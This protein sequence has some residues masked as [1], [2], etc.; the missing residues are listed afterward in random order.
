MFH[1]T[2]NRF[3]K[4]RMRGSIIYNLTKDILNTSVMRRGDYSKP[5]LEATSRAFL[6]S[7]FCFVP[8]GYTC[9][10]RRFYDSFASACI[11][12][13]LADSCI[14]FPEEI[15]YSTIAI[16]AGDMRC[17]QNNLQQKRQW[18]NSI[19]QKSAVDDTINTEVFQQFACRGVQAF[20]SFF[21]Y[22]NGATTATILR[23]FGIDTP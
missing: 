14:A 12:I 3:N 10:S 19:V 18:L 7:K 22:R 4:G 2:M 15:D 9:T 21:S 17:I 1:G 11:P 5:H 6:D 13:R 16:E 23:R 8:A 20:R